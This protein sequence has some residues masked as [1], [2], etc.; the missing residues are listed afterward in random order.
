MPDFRGIQLLTCVLVMLVL[1]SCVLLGSSEGAGP[2]ETVRAT[3][4]NDIEGL[5]GVI[6]MEYLPEAAM[7][8]VVKIGPES[9]DPRLPGPTD[10]YLVAVLTYTPS[11]IH[12]I[13]SATSDHK[14]DIYVDTSFI[15]AWYPQ[16]VKSAFIPEEETGLLMLD[17]PSYDPEPFTTS[18]WLTGYLFFPDNETVFLFLAS[19]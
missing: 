12:E 4:A 11:V 2:G 3:P 1:L 6:N 19:R 8:Q 10:A 17:R 13:R 16:S 7:W 9:E 18:P 15:E 14:S 5:A